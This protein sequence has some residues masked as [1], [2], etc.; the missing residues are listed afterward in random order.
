MVQNPEPFT[1][2][3]LQVGSNATKIMMKWGD[4]LAKAQAIAAQPASM[5]IFNQHGKAMFSPPLPSEIEG[6]PILFSNRGE[7]Q[8][9]MYEYAGSIGVKF[10]FGTRVQEYFETQTGAGVVVDGERIDV[11]GVIAAD[12]VHSSARKYITNV[13]QH[14]RTSG[15]AVYRCRFDR[16]LLAA[17][18]LTKAYAE[19]DKDTFHVW[20]GTDVHAILFIIVAAETA[21]IYCT[22]KA[23]NWSEDV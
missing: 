22:H 4:T 12:G 3:M 11:D 14:P 21:V 1:G 18:P 5:T 10:R 23:S 7:L 8:I 2:D 9:L 16:A 17:N 19:T 13:H 6:A 20:L 15:F